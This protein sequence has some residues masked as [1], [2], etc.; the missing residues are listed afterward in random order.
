MGLTP[1]RDTD[2]RLA[3]QHGAQARHIACLLAHRGDGGSV[4][5]DLPICV[6]TP[7]LYS[8]RG[9][10]GARVVIS[11]GDG[12]RGLAELHG[13]QACHLTKLVTLAV[14]AVVAELSI[15]VPPPTLDATRSEEGAGMAITRRDGDGRLSELHDAQARHLTWLIALAVGVA[16]AELSMVVPSP[17][18]DATRGEDGAGVGDASGDGGGRLAEVHCAQARHIAWCAAFAISAVVAELPK[19]V[20]SPTLDAARGEDG[21]GVRTASRDGGG[22]FA[23]LHGA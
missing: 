5:A 7:A 9:E 15:V 13:A 17:T 4:V 18:L 23:Q 3:E 2:G 14:S 11:S 8:A 22:S 16:V 20:V 19:E 1:N 12:A 10:E 6:A 21:A